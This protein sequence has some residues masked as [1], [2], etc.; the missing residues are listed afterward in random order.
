[1]KELLFYVL[2]ILFF[3][4][5]LEKR[6]R[7]RVLILMFHQI[8]NKNLNFYKSMPTNVF[9]ELCLFIKKNYAVL[10][11]SEVENH[12]KTSSK[13][14]AIISFD[15]GHYDIIKNVLPILKKL[16][17]PFNI[18]IDTE[19]FKTR[20]P[21]DFVRVY[22]ILNHC[23]ITSYF[24]SEFMK[25]PIEIDKSSPT[26]AEK[27][28]TDILSNLSIKKRREF[29]EK[30]AVSSNMP[31]T[32]YSK[33]LSKDDVK[34]LSKYKVEFGS[35][36]YSH[37]I[38]TNLTSKELHYELTTSKKDL[39]KITNKKVNILAYPN[40]I[41]DEEVENIAKGLGFKILLQTGNKINKINK[42]EEVIESWKRINQYHQSLNGALAH[43]Y[44][45][46]KILNI[47]LKYFKN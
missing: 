26:K 44:G 36:S 32:N 43:I 11:P 15:D 12:F 16:D 47:V 34:L 5:F 42:K 21:Q 29:V 2:N 17:L 3:N 7:N 38:L 31:E 19:I 9:K 1:M 46:T 22:D 23:N 25:V 45:K 20:K 13:P 28:F 4:Y 39:E 40:G 8:N 10:L 37:P 35:H 33:M 30:M 24:D 27:E 6:K 14:V 18:N 41:Y